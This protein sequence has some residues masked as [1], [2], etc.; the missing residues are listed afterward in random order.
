M[1][2]FS[3]IFCI[4]AA[5]AVMVACF[6][7][8]ASAASVNSPERLNLSE[9]DSLLPGWYVFR[10]VI[11]GDNL[12][13][14]IDFN[15]T[16]GG[17]DYHGLAIGFNVDDSLLGS[18]VLY[19]ET[20]PELNSM[21]IWTSNGYFLY[22]DANLIYVNSGYVEN[23]AQADFLNESLLYLGDSLETPDAESVGWYNNIYDLVVTHIFG[24]EINLTPGMEFSASLVATVISIVAFLL[25]ILICVFI[26]RFLFAWRM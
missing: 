12:Y 16:A 24:G 26:I 21:I 2:K 22:P 20:A 4:I 19:Y 23:D 10:D 17:Y 7:I 3:K 11:V 8:P 18:G 6:A 5:V 13:I 25:P 14:S 1:K 15:F 9:G